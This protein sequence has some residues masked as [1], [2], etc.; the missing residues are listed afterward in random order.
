[1]SG[2]H[3]THYTHTTHSTHGSH[4]THSNT[5]STHSTHSDHASHASHTSHSNHSTHNNAAPTNADLNIT[6]PS[7]ADTVA[8]ID[9][10]DMSVTM[11]TV[12]PVRSGD[13]VKNIDASIGIE[14]KTP[15]TTPK[16][17]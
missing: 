17:K 13:T 2:G 1:N 4:S 11:G 16:T 8:P 3:T 6:A 14:I 10:G 5:H 12:M 15:P 9:A 7:M